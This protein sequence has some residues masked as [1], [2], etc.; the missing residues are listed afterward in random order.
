MRLTALV[1][2]L[3]LGTL[4]PGF[5]WSYVSSIDV[6]DRSVIADGRTFGRYGAYERLKGRVCIAIDP[7]NDANRRITDIENAPTNAFGEVEACANFMVLQPVIPQL[8]SGVGW[9]EVSNRG[10]KASL[11]Y[12]NAA[13]EGSNDPQFIEHIGDGFLMEQGFTIMWVGWQYDVPPGDD[14]LWLDAPRATAGPPIRGLV[15]SDWRVDVDTP[16]LSLGHNSLP[17]YYGVANPASSRN[18]LT[19]RS[20]RDAEP[21]IIPRRRWRV[22]AIDAET[23]EFE[24]TQTHI[25]LEG[26]FKAGNI[27]EFVYE[28][29]DP[30]VEGLG[31]AMIRDFG[32]FAKYGEDT[33]FPVETLLGFG[34]SQTGRFL[35]HYLYQDFNGDE[36]G[37]RVFDGLM[38]HTAGAGRGSFNHR[39]GQ[40]SRDAHQNSAFFYPTDIYPFTSEV[41]DNPL[42]GD[43]VG[44]FDGVFDKETLPRIFYTNSG[45]EYWGRA[46]S[47]IHST[48]DG[49]DDTQLEDFERVYHIAG[50][51]HFVVGLPPN[52]C[53]APGRDP[54]IGSP[55]DMLVNLRALAVRLRDWADRGREPPPSRY[56]S[57]DARTL[58][59]IEDV[60]FPAIPGVAF[61][62]RLHHAYV[63]DYGPRWG[64]GIIDF[65][66]PNR[67][68]VITPM[69]SQV[70]RL[71]NEVAGVQNVELQV[72][73][74]TY[75][76]WNL[77]TD[78]QFGGA[79][80]D[81]CGSFLPLPRSEVL[82]RLT[83]DPRPSIESLY[84][85]REDYR[86]KVRAAAER[87]VRQGF[88]LER[89]IDRV[90]AQNDMIWDWIFPEELPA[91]NSASEDGYPVSGADA[92]EEPGVDQS[93][94]PGETPAEDRAHQD[95]G[96][97]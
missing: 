63:A 74:A 66:P 30:V 1:T 72:P 87:L 89:D 49:R 75:T 76:P 59:S 27:Y 20:E 81:F 92:G 4:W 46:A 19:V 55:V 38:I 33:P 88:L 56:P 60:N 40:P 34:V 41:Q 35:R 39:F 70:N 61:P 28:A 77:R 44:L 84:P 64:E 29:V 23:G 15:R 82:K 94:N 78:G 5:A 53:S 79:L 90:V 9:L 85:N 25:T 97:R 12:F 91:Q 51:Q 26:S 73:L 13:S 47:L 95:R 14:R 65:Q 17:A 16:S 21:R 52:R 71:G 57:H 93:E 86:F 50:A 58:V 67:L 31:L 45:Y 24:P 80:T 48:M 42:G 62:E 68:D 7:D 69:V 11:R 8:R 10:G 2:G 36:E 54:N 43:D 6:E 3:M 83:G 22:G 96:I 37:E 32:S 18:Q